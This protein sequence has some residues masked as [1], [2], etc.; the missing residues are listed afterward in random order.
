MDRRV[1][2]QSVSFS[3]IFFKGPF[4]F[5]LRDYTEKLFNSHHL[6]IRRDYNPK[7]K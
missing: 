2:T 1:N 4:F 7:Y 6:A 3:A 5:E